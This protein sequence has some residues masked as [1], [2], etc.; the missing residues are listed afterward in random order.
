MTDRRVHKKYTKDYYRPGDLV[1]RKPIGLPYW[2]ASKGWRRYTTDDYGLGIVLEEKETNIEQ[3][4]FRCDDLVT[5]Y[6]QGLHIRE[7]IHKRFIRRAV[8]IE[9]RGE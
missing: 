2:D 5:V 3:L 1:N 9:R 8:L 6:W 7:T 4:Q